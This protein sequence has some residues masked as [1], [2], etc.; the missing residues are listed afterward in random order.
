MTRLHPSLFEECVKVLTTFTHLWYTQIKCFGINP[1]PKARVSPVLFLVGAYRTGIELGSSLS[2]T[3][4]CQGY[5]C[6]GGD[7]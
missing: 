2:N 7:I 1:C 4:L 6:E 3:R 5:P